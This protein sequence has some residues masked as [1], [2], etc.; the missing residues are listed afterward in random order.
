MTEPTPDA[1]A[2]MLDGGPALWLASGEPGPVA[3]DVG[4]V[5]ETSGSTGRPQRVALT[6]AQLRAAAE[7]GRRAHGF[8]A[9]WH[10]ALPAHYVAGL[11]VLVRGVL[12]RGVRECGSDLADLAPAP[13]RNCLSIVPTQL[14]RALDRGIALDGFDAVLVGGAPL[15]PDVRRRAATAGVAVVE[16]YGMSETCGGVVHDGVPLPGVDVDIEGGRIRLSGPMVTGGTILTNDRGEWSDGRL[17][18][19]GRVDD[20]VITGG[21]K[22]DL[23][24]VRD[25]VGALDRDAWVLAVDDREWGQRIVLFARSGTLDGW[26]ERLGERLPRHALPRQLVLV[27]PLPRTAGGKPD[28]AQLLQLVAERTRCQGHLRHGGKRGASWE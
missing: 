7:A 20:L 18:V 3:G 27:D 11:M 24:I 16:T 2:Q 28:R 23:A 25:E 5:L 4:V 14:I 1:V 12:G 17:R 6:R 19:L 8:D 15:A 9:T 21:L 13:G 26:R 22:A 10:L